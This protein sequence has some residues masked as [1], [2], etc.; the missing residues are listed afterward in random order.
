MKSKI[1]AIAATIL[2]TLALNAN[3]QGLVRGTVRD[4]SGEPLPGASVVIANSQVGVLTDIDGKYTIS[5][6]SKDVL[7]F[8]F[9]GFQ[10]KKEQVGSRTVIDVI[11]EDDTSALEEAIVVGYGTQSKQN[12]TNAVSSVKGAELLKAPA[13]GVSTMVGTRVAGV[14]ALQ[15]SGQPGADAASLL[16][17]G[18]S[19]VYIVDGVKRD[20]NEIDPNEVESVSVLKDATS[21]A[22]YGLDAT[23]VI[24]VT[25]KRGDA[26]RTRISYNGE[27]GISRNTNMLE[28]LNG[29]DFAWWYNKT[30]ELDAEAAGKEFVPVFTAQN[31]QD[32][33]DGKN[34]W[35]NTNW[36]EKTFGTGTTQHH[37]INASGG[38]DRS[39]FFASLGYF[40]QNG[41]VQNF[42][43]KRYN[44]RSNVDTKINDFLSFEM[45][46][47]GRLEIRD[48][49]KYSA[50]PDDWH[51]IPQ[52]A[53]RALPYVPETYEIDGVSYPVSTQDNSSWENPL[54]S[55]T[56]SGNYNARSTYLQTNVALRYD[57]P[58]IKGLW[59]RA[60]GAY[61]M[62]FQNTR[63]L[64]T[65][66]YTAM[67]TGKVP[68]PGTE[69]LK[70]TLTTDAGGNT[71]S[72]TESA[73]WAYN[74]TTNLSAN[75][76][77]TF[78]K[79][80][81]KA[82]AFVETRETKS[83][84]IGATGYGLDFLNLAELDNVTNKTGAGSEMNPKVSGRSNNTRTA[85]FAGRINYSYDQ[86]YLLELSCRYDGSYIFSKKA[87][88]R[89]VVLPGLSAGWNVHK[90]DWFD[91]D[92][93][94]ELKLR[95]SVGKSA[96]SNGLGRT[97]YVDLFSLSN[98]AVV[99]NGVNQAMVYASVLGNPNLTWA[100][101]NNYDLGVDFN[102]WN[103]LLGFEFDVFYKYEYDILS[104]ITGA[105]SPS[106]GGYYYTYGNDNKRDY[107][108]FDFTIH[109]DN[110]IGD[111]NYGAKLMFTYAYRRWLYYAGDSENMPDYQRRTGK[112]VGSLYGFIADGLFQSEEEIMT[113][114]TIPGAKVAPG[115]IKY[116]D[117]NGDGQIT[118]YQD[119]GLVAASA[120]PRVQGS[121]NLYANWKGFDI[122]LLF[123]GATGRT[124]SLTG[125]YTASGASGIEDNTFLTKAFYHGGNSPYFLFERAWSH[126]NPE[127]EF[128]RPS[129]V[130]LSSNNAYASTFWYRDGSYLRLKTMQI[131]Y[132]IPAKLT[133]KVGISSLRFYLQ[134]SN[135][136]TL[137]ALTKYNVDPEQAAVNNG[138]YPQQKVYQ[139]GVKVS[140]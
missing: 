106:R 19:A 64:S 92:W 65:P 71:T 51:N 119:R 42:N 132:T 55:S 124:V 93:I 47:A 11:L 110:Y 56:L 96:T 57:V 62:S 59:F 118:Y 30:L 82:I 137:S 53:V 8:S 94:N 140:F 102:A 134:G 13:V 20:M 81:I 35:G 113:S 7:E 27:Y 2:V 125:V 104:S 33:L 63:R 61:D 77:N 24:L 4:S 17:R 70:Y 95:A 60:M 34:G 18:Q 101:I 89:W 14:V 58:F 139:L 69:E 103:G 31:V 32:M 28:L 12:L 41:N 45:N 22:M 116:V 16:V 123:Q 128:P 108:G 97:N 73:Y 127:G 52:Q 29:P 5:C 129:I 84:T 109:H 121:L 74:I 120:Y 88:S 100:K 130:P 38:N 54:A 40:D 105:Y 66:Y 135:L 76:E 6:S 44:I 49:P 83:H 68:A 75:Y 25:T 43:Y 99:L 107:R 90:E 39:K 86:K 98:N 117:R 91:Y 50:N 26:Q 15:Q 78:G 46:L 21:A 37:S 115:Y 9:L 136:F 10:T 112:E 114:P 126:E 3:A 23:S 1:F 85:G 138:Y 80:A 79:H 122:D 67:R 72:L 48:Q 36:Y 133:R 111:L 87:G 131:G